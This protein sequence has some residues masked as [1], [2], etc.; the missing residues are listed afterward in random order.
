MSANNL[1]FN[2]TLKSNGSVVLTDT[3]KGFSNVTAAATAAANAAD[4]AASATKKVGFD[5]QAAANGG[6]QLA[7]AVDKLGLRLTMLNQGFQLMRRLGGQAFGTLTDKSFLA[8]AGINDDAT[9]VISGGASLLGGAASGAA[10]GAMIG[11]PIGAAVGAAAG[12]LMSAGQLLIEAAKEQQKMNATETKKSNQESWELGDV[13]SLTSEEDIDERLEKL[14]EKQAKLREE[15]K[16][17]NAPEMP[18]AYG[19]NAIENAKYAFG[20][21]EYGYNMLSGEQA[22]NTSKS[23]NVD[24]EIDRL[25]ALKDKKWKGED[26]LKDNANRI[27]KD[28]NRDIAAAN[29]YAVPG[30][31]ARSIAEHEKL[32]NRATSDISQKYDFGNLEDAGTVLA[33]LQDK[34]L[35]LQ[36]AAADGDVDAA[37]ELAAGTFAKDIATLGNLTAKQRDYGTQKIIDAKT[38]TDAETDY[39]AAGAK[40]QLARDGDIDAYESAMHRITDEAQEAARKVEIAQ[41]GKVSDSAELTRKGA[42]E[43]LTAEIEN[44]RH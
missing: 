33:K 10:G 15:N 18:K 43:T 24:R 2:I 42:K 35:G 37:K 11:G 39:Q 9:S 13:T 28:A 6:I 40:R 5:F 14:R 31:A 17:L 19:F 12:T 25:Q 27:A 4:K 34:V 41:T 22:A 21:I 32:T 3:A 26:A 23:F 16:S 36:T 8:G 30:A 20:Q 1:L 29:I 38:Q 7:S 44:M